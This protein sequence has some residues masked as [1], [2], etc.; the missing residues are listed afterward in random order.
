M[1]RLSHIFVSNW[2]NGQYYFLSQLHAQTFLGGANTPAGVGSFFISQNW[3]A[4]IKYKAPEAFVFCLV[5]PVCGEKGV[6][7]VS[8]VYL[9]LNNCNVYQKVQGE[10]KFRL[11]GWSQACQTII[12]LVDMIPTCSCIMISV[13]LASHQPLS[14]TASWLKGDD[15]PMTRKGVDVTLGHGPLLLHR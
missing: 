6:Q 2:K 10:W 15:V 13:F 8:I 11:C 4:L 12:V 5:K 9:N 3:L 7:P 14:F 1:K